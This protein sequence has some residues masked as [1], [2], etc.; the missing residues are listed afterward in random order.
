MAPSLDNTF[1]ALA[2]KS[3]RDIISRLRRGPQRSTALADDLELSRPAVSKHLRILRRAGLIEQEAIE[4]DARV[5]LVHL[6]REPF[7]RLRGWLDE[8]E[9]FWGDQL[10]AFKAHAES[11]ARRDRR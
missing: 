2:D 4:S 5:R 7:A 3:R 1:I 6:R 10:A 9:A 8:V 11:K